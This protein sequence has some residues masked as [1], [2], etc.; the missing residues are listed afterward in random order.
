MFRDCHAL[1]CMVVLKKVYARL[2][3]VWV[4][5]LSIGGNTKKTFDCLHVV[6]DQD[7]MENPRKL[8]FFLYLIYIILQHC[9]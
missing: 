3:R 5:V 8:K 6:D 2:V 1:V 7:I 9:I 4:R